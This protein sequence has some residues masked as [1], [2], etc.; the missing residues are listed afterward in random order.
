MNPHLAQAAQIT[1]KSLLNRE[2]YEVE[3]GDT[4]RPQL[5]EA[6]PE[7]VLKKAIG[8]GGGGSLHEIGPYWMYEYRPDL[9]IRFT[10]T[11]NGQ[12][13]D[14]IIPR[15]TTIQIAKQLLQEAS[16]QLQLF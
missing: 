2:Y 3:S 9:T 6:T 13:I 4:C 11:E 12:N 8:L 15:K 1:I 10:R 5:Q 7:L 16:G 14:D